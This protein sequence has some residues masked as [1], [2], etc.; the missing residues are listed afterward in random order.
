MDDQV[1]RFLSQF[2]GPIHL[3]LK[4]PSRLSYVL[5]SCMGLASLIPA[6]DIYSFITILGFVFLGLLII[7]FRFQPGTLDLDDQAFVVKSSVTNKTVRIRWQDASNFEVGKGPMFGGCCPSIKRNM[8]VY[9]NA[10]KEGT[11]VGDNRS[12][13]LDTYEGFTPETLARLMTHW[14]ERA[15]KS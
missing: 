12:F 9:D 5:V 8:V 1:A 10:A 6:W 4:P 13:L 7:L 14:R 15:I 3:E 11:E 2:P